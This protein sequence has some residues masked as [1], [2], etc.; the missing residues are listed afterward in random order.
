MERR[1]YAAVARVEWPGQWAS[2]LRHYKPN[3]VVIAFGTNESGYPEICRRLHLGTR[4]ESR[5]APHS[6]SQVPG[7]GDFTDEV[8]WIAGSGRDDGDIKEQRWKRCPAWWTS[9]PR[10]RPSLNV[11]FFNTFEAMG[12]SGTMAR[13][14][15]GEPRLVGADFIHPMP[16]GARIVGELLYNALRDGYKEYKLRQLKKLDAGAE[17]Q[18]ASARSETSN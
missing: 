14:Y 3:L 10:R 2:E 18:S 1:H 7:G 5:G 4:I 15:N 13:W 9:N 12:G 6:G 17:T 16:A 11:A 8:R